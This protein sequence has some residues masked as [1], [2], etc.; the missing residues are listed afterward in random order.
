MTPFVLTGLLMLVVA[1]VFVVPVL[2]RAS[3]ALHESP[4]GA[5][6]S[7]A[8]ERKTAL[9]L[10]LLLALLCWGAY[11]LVGQPDALDASRRAPVAS[12]PTLQQAAPLPDEE[13]PQVG[14]AQIQAM[15]SRLAQRLQSQ[16]ND[17]EGWRMLARSYETLGRF[18]EAVQAYQ[19]L[20]ALRVPDPDLL[21]DYAVT[22]GMSENH[23]LV[24]E[25]EKL[26]AQALKL[27]PNHVQALALAGSAAFE[28]RD[29]ARAIS[30]WEKIVAL[31]PPD[32]EVRHTIELN[33]D[34][35]RSL[36]QRDA[37]QQ[38]P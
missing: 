32:A 30:Q 17:P 21:T 24:G 29:Y 23:T 35:A 10:V 37:R 28:R 22:L 20:L 12:A 16:P 13:M 6:V 11:R 31:L 9:V 8:P 14:P 26:I 4:E 5:E 19:R 36:A 1:S 33:I 34:K 38:R 15:V 2:W 7:E 3:G 27:N 25:P 18:P